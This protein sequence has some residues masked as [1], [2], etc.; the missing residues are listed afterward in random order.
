M[1]LTPV[2]R[3][4]PIPTMPNYDTQYF[5]DKFSAIP[6][7]LWIT[8]EF[9][10]PD[11]P[12]QRCAYGHCGCDDMSDENEEA[13]CLDRLFRDHGLRVPPVNDGE[14]ARDSGEFWKLPTPKARILAALES[15]K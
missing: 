14:K 1:N 12:C 7:E 5:I 15:F 9:Q 3:T 13:N 4:E 8:G 11:K 6:E 10:N 2:N